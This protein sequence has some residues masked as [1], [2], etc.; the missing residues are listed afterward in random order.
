M[1]L[2]S[3]PR[4][5]LFRAMSVWKTLSRQTA[6]EAQP[7]LRI[8][9]EVIEV[10][11]GKVIDDFWQVELRSFTLVVPVLE[12]GRVAVLTGYRHGPRR[13]CMSLPGGHVDAGE[14]AEAAAIRELAEE[15][16]LATKRLVPLGEFVDN[17]NQRGCRGHYFLALECR[18]A[19]APTED[20]TEAADV[21]F[22]TA[23]EVDAALDGGQFGVIHH[24]AGWCLA[25]HHPAF[26]VQPV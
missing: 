15:T 12:D 25:R 21:S 24:V 11:P 2:D 19:T 1:S 22:L 9:R 13:I 26:P 10:A 16:G 20:V 5:R 14:T 23:A 3:G 18:Q 7:Y 4:L 17:G 6:F 8:V